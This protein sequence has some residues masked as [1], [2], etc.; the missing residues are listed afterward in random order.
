M[1]HTWAWVRQGHAG[2]R[3]TGQRK[4][5]LMRPEGHRRRRRPRSSQAVAAQVHRPCVLD[6]VGENNLPWACGSRVRGRGAAGG[7]A[8]A[9][10]RPHAAAALR[11]STSRPAP[12]RLPIADAAAEAR[13]GRTEGRSGSACSPVSRP[14]VFAAKCGLRHAVCAALSPRPQ[15]ATLIER[16]AAGLCNVCTQC[17]EAVL[18]AQHRDTQHTVRGAAR[19]HRLYSARTLA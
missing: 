4:P 5:R 9:L 13:L 18:T 8:E 11:G 3:D 7:A 19:R 10:T 1:S 6:S 2:R 16:C 12:A 14:G 15:A 17:T